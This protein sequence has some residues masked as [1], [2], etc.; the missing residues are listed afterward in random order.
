MEGK[1]VGEEEERRHR[2]DVQQE[3][4]QWRQWGEAGMLDC[5]ISAAEYLMEPGVFI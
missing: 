2:E 5:Q 1:G 3:R 4:S